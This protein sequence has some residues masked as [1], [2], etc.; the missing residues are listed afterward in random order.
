MAKY[1]SAALAERSSAEKRQGKIFE[2]LYKK[3]DRKEDVPTDLVEFEK[4]KEECTFKPN[5]ED[6]SRRLSKIP[7]IKSAA[8]KETLSQLRPS[9]A[10]VRGR[11]PKSSRPIAVDL[12]AIA[13][14]DDGKKRPQTSSLKRPYIKPIKAATKAVP[15]EDP[16]SQTQKVTGVA[17]TSIALKNTKTPA[18]VDT[19]AKKTA[20]LSQL[21]QKKSS[22]N[23]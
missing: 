17:K 12:T 20:A 22:Q 13:K 5:L 19:K 15:K 18:V 6:S 7:G 10:I 16:K 9:T 2:E 21:N 11:S 4:N 1:Q 14:Q 3:K 23:V 8:S